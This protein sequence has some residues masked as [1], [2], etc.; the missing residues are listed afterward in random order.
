MFLKIVPKT[1]DDIGEYSKM[2]EDGKQVEV[3]AIL[4]DVEKVT[5]VIKIKKIHKTNEH[6][7]D[8]QIK[9]RIKEEIYHIFLNYLNEKIGIKEGV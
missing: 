2:I 1:I 5:S 7:V 6:S 4:S 9:G 8:I 3:T